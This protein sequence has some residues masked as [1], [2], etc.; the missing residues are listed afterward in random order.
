MDPD[1]I[2]RGTDPGTRIRT[3]MSWIPNTGT[4]PT[5]SCFQYAVARYTLNYKKLR[6]YICAGIFF[7]IY[8]HFRRKLNLSKIDGTF[9]LIPTGEVVSGT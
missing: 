6:K 9:S 5:F 8:A 3:K 2:V 4:V 1:P 7:A